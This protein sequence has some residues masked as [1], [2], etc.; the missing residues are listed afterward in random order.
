[1]AKIICPSASRQN[2]PPTRDR[3]NA[4]SEVTT[5]RPTPTNCHTAWARGQAKNK[6][7]QSSTALAHSGH[8][9]G[10]SGTMR[11]H[12]DLVIRHCRSRSQANNLTFRWRRRFHTKR[13][14]CRRSRSSESSWSRSNIYADWA[15]KPGPLHTHV[16]WATSD[17]RKS[18]R[19]SCRLNSSAT[20]SSG[21]AWGR[22]ETQA[23]CQARHTETPRSVDNA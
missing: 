22:A 6:C 15:M 14:L 11:F 4:S 5:R 16:S 23:S 1:M 2:V 18:A 3:Q 13:H 21:N 17:K 8:F 12:K 20:H 7:G 19:S 9:T 10:E